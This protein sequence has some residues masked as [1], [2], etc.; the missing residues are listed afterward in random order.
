MHM[1]ARTMSRAAPPFEADERRLRLLITDDDPIQRAFGTAYLEKT[2]G[3]VD[4][5]EN[6]EEGLR[7][8][9]SGGYDIALL[10]IDMPGMS[11]I[12]MLQ[13]IRAVPTLRKL[14]VIMVTSHTDVASI[15]KA[16]K[17][18]ASSFYTKPVNWTLLSYHIRFVV[19]A[20]EGQ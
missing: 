20:I 2:V 11:G 17:L 19:R 3:V 1:E 14:P 12:E 16:Y 5:A 10:D 13:A 6:A 9:V 4:T 18:G 8:L 7:R 15:D